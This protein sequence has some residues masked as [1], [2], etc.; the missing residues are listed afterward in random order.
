MHS[1]ETMQ[2]RML[3]CRNGSI[4]L[5]MGKIRYGGDCRRSQYKLADSQY[6]WTLGRVT[7]IVF[8]LSIILQL[9]FR[10]SLP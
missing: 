10:I 1:I 9:G 2:V 8:S 7:C 3:L 4:E 6:I 5:S